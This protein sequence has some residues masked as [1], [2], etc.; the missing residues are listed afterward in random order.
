MSEFLGD[1]FDG[2]Y[3]LLL[4]LAAAFLRLQAVVKEDRTAEHFRGRN[5][6]SS[7]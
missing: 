1:L 4:G 7:S 2:L 6:L 5:Q 3:P